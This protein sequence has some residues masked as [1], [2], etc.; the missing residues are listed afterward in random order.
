MWQQLGITDVWLSHCTSELLASIAGI[1]FH[2]WSLFAVNFRDEE[3]SAGI[4]THKD[5]GTRKYLAS[6]IGAH[7]DHYL[8]TTRLKLKTL[9][10]ETDIL[11]RVSDK[12]HFEDI[13]YHEQISRTKL[14]SPPSLATEIRDYNEVLCDSVFSLCPAGAGPNTLRLWESMAAGA[15]PVMLGPLPLLP[16]GGTLPD[17][18]WDEIVVTVADE[19]IGELPAILRGMSLTERRTRQ[20]AALKAY[21]AVALQRCFATQTS[22]QLERG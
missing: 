20:G 9:A 1:T 18:N 13:V 16:S 15:I 22:D 2:P 4:T 14:L 3:R 6:F 21:A 17:I 11:I 5:V 7:C 8:S 12:W 10:N 19:R